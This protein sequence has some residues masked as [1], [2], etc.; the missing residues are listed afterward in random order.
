MK[1]AVWIFCCFVAITDRAVLSGPV[2]SKDVSA[3]VVGIDKCLG[4]AHTPTVIDISY[5]YES[6]HIMMYGRIGVYLGTHD[7]RQ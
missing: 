1:V 3:G 2:L 7:Y 6:A 5:S 4:K